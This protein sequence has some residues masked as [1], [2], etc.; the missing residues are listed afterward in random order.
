MRLVITRILISL[1][2]LGS[3][4]L[5]AALGLVTIAA[6]HPQNAML[7]TSP[8]LCSARP[9]T[10]EPNTTFGCTEATIPAWQCFHVHSINASVGPSP[11]EA[12]SATWRYQSN[13]QYS[14]TAVTTSSGSVAERYAY[15]AYGQPTILDGSG[16]VL[17]SSAINNRYAY[18][19]REWDATLGLYHFRARWMSGL[20]GRFMG[21]DPIGFSGGSLGL[22]EYCGSK[23]QSM[24][25]PSGNVWGWDDFINH[26]R[27]GH[28]APVTLAQI[29][30]LETYKAAHKSK[31]FNIL[32]NAI[33]LGGVFVNCN[34]GP[35]SYSRSIPGPSG[36]DI[37]DSTRVIRLFPLGR[38]NI[39]WDS[40]VDISWTC[41][42]C[43]ASGG[44]VKVTSIDLIAKAKFKLVDSFSDTRPGVP[45]D[46]ENPT[47][48]G[49]CIN[50]CWNTFIANKKWDWS[51]YRK[52]KKNCRKK[53]PTNDP[54]G[55]PYGISAEWEDT[56]KESSR[57]ACDKPMVVIN[58]PRWS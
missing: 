23:P 43:C 45:N 13:Q 36:H 25:D 31:V 40:S 28:G 12:T 33:G 11:D 44:D 3:K 18:T 5:Q 51:S 27:N 34:D 8:E 32:S 22:F 37:W 16:S 21:R 29:G 38:S 17:S 6:M 52:C 47:Q 14:I 58:D 54:Y 39:Y 53:F 42:Y 48:Q 9:R 15:T 19:G 7:E 20:A 10:G 50:D 41:E 35:G 4:S 49:I 2:I 24:V 55:V 56:M 26:Y 46:P 57:G 30:L 1:R